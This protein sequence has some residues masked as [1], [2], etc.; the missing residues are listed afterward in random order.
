[1]KQD[2]RSRLKPLKYM[3]GDEMRDKLASRLSHNGWWFNANT[4]DALCRIVK[5][6]NKS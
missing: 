2:K 3:S 1:M 6:G 4:I 5:R